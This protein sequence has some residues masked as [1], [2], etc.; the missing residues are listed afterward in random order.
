MSKQDLGK[1]WKVASI[2]MLREGW[3]VQN[4]TVIVIVDIRPYTTKANICP[5]QMFGYTVSD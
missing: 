5:E 2:P 4:V 1:A 3:G